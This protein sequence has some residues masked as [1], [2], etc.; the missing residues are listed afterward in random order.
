[1]TGGP[2]CI[3]S[4]SNRLE[5][6]EQ[7]CTV[8]EDFAES[9]GVSAGTRHALLLVVEELFANTVHYGYDGDEKDT[10]TIGASYLDGVMRLSIRDHARP[11][12][13]TA[14]P[15]QPDESLSIDEMQIGG[16]GLFLVHEFAQ[17]LVQ[18]R[19]GKAN[20]TEIVLKNVE[21]D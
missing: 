5:E 1:M 13:V 20:T 8:L 6:L 2:S 3:V 17:S 7:I 11:F 9:C 19:D 14:P 4:V 12:D 15:R 18:Q 16:L 21:A 10:V